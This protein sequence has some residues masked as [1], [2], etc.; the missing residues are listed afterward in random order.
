[1]VFID[2]GMINILPESPAR[3][4]PAPAPYADALARLHAVSR[5][6]DATRA[7]APLP[8]AD[9]ARA[10]ELSSERGRKRMEARADEVAAAAAAGLAVLASL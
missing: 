5:M 8:D 7:V 1:M 4:T 10:W 2:L 3:P 6:L 9:L